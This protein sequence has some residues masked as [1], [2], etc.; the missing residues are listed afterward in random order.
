VYFPFLIVQK[1]NILRQI[2][3]ISVDI[4]RTHV[5]KPRVLPDEL[6]PPPPYIPSIDDDDMALD[7]SETLPSTSRLPDPEPNRRVFRTATD[8]Y[9][10]FRE[11]S[12]G[13]PSITP[14]ENYNLSDVTDSPHMA[15]DNPSSSA[16]ASYLSSTIDR[17]REGATAAANAATNTA[18]TFFAPFRNPSIYRLMAWFYSSSNTKSITELNSLVNDVI[19]APDFKPEDFIGFSTTKEQ[20]VMDAHQEASSGP[21]E[22]SSPFEFDD[23]WIKGTVEISLPCDGFAFESEDEAPKFV[24]EVYYRKLIEVIKS[25]LSEPIAEKFHTF[26]FRAFWKA[27]PDEPE[28]RI[29]S[30]IFTG[31][32]WNTEYEK[33]QS[34]HLQGP[35]R[36]LEAFIIALMIWSDSTCLAQFG[37][38][39]LWPIYLYLGNLSKYFRGKSTSFA[40]HHIAYIPKVCPKFIS[41]SNYLSLQLEYRLATVFKNSISKTLINRQQKL[42]SDIFGE[43]SFRLFGFY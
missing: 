31:E 22:K 32:Y 9:G 19:L 41:V 42:C 43:S 1:I 20:A 4:P 40:A 34:A 15:F 10:V 28:E 2:P 7:C 12:N 37:T 3:D 21:N 38:A 27:A 14:D 11:Y 6:P 30:E 23:T 24:V 29:Y 13:I 39:E 18:T 35:N 16:P 26:P 17:L 33:L 5:Q 8:G 25:A 36:H